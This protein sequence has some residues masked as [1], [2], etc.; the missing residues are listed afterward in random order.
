VTNVSTPLR[1]RA[2]IIAAGRGERLRNGLSAAVKPLVP[3]DGQALIDRVLTSIGEASPDEVVIIV[4]HDDA[5]AVREHVER[6]RWPF[7][8]RWIVENT[9][10]S[11]HSFL[12]VLEALCQD[13][14]PGPF[15][16][17]TV[18]TVAPPG[19]YGR[20]LERARV[21]GADVV[22]ALTRSIG[23]DRPL[24][25]DVDERTMQVLRIGDA[26]RSGVF[27]TAGWYSVRASVLADAAA[28]RRDGL[29]A[30]RQFFTRLLTSGYRVAGAEVPRC[31]DVDR[32]DDVRDAEA[33]V[34]GVTA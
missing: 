21:T 18:D 8:L 22:L 1:T 2:G 14:Q 15:L 28:A 5:I 7:A 27:C 3:V 34:K 24:L 16:M 33:L 29:S 4:N 23:D 30:L 6:T 19:S 17:S 13:G 12:L 10:S 9:P 25:V 26:S 31:V 11:M 20:F 32:P